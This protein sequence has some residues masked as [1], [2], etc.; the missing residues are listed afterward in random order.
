VKRAARL[1]QATALSLLVPC[2]GAAIPR[3]YLAVG[4]G[5]DVLLTDLSGDVVDERV[6]GQLELGIG[7]QIAGSLA[8]EATFGVLEAQ[9]QDPPVL[10]LDVDELALS[11]SART[12]RVE[13]NPI[14]LRLRYARGG[15][16]KGYLKPELHAGVGLVSVTRWLRQVPGLE[17]PSTNELFTALEA[18]A[19]ALLVL[20]TNFTMS[21]GARYTLMER[22]DIVDATDHLDGLSVLLGFRI[23]LNSPADEADSA[24]GPAAGNDAP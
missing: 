22:N 20:G 12:F 24:A 15:V 1:V 21:C 4:A 7:T 16:R 10:P 23:F 8:L 13:A 2:T 5:A 14:M 11:E 6:L 18:G 9:Q 17:P 3:T 19:S